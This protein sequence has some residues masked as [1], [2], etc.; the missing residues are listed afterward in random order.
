MFYGGTMKIS[1]N[2]IQVLLVIL[3]FII[4]VSL[5][6][7]KSEKDAMQ[8]RVDQNFVGAIS[9]SMSGLSVDY[10]KLSY[11]EK[12][13]SYYKTIYGLKNAQDCFHI[14]S[15]KKNEGMFEALNG[16]YIYLLAYNHKNNDYEIEDKS[17]IYDTIWKI[18]GQ[19]E[20]KK[21]TT[22]FNAFIENKKKIL[23]N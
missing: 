22:K 7:V 5:Y 23:N 19:P 14:S 18:V 4:S 10:N 13:K 11:E 6:I 20:D 12:I 8:K 9:D 21:L 16:L 3:L 15:Y 1:R 17:Y 2:A